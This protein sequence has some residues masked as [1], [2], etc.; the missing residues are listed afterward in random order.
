MPDLEKI[1]IFTSLF[2]EVI[3]SISLISTSNFFLS[4]SNQKFSCLISLSDEKDFRFKIFQIFFQFFNQNITVLFLAKISICIILVELS[5]I[6]S[7]FFLS[8]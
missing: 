3:S 8:L 5:E 2:L 6:L 1:C 4:T 7:V